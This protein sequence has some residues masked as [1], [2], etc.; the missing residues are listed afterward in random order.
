MKKILLGTTALVAATA[1]TAGVAKAD[2]SVSGWAY[3]SLGVTINTDKAENTAGGTTSYQNAG[4]D[5]K[6]STEMDS[7][8]TASL[9]FDFKAYGDTGGSVDEMKMS[10][11][12]DWGTLQLGTDDTISDVM[13][14][15]ANGV[16][17]NGVNDGGWDAYVGDGAALDGT[18]FMNTGKSLIGSDLA[19]VSYFSPSMNGLTFGLSYNADSSDNWTSSA[20]DSGFNNVWSAAAE[21]D[22][23]MSG[24]AVNLG[25]GAEHVADSNLV[26]GD[27]ADEDITLWK[28]NGS[29]G[30][31]GFSA[32]ATYQALD[33]NTSTTAKVDNWTL[34][35]SLGYSVAQH[36]MAVTW[37]TGEEDTG[38]AATSVDGDAYQISYSMDLGS[39][40]YW[41]ANLT[42]FDNQDGTTGNSSTR[43]ADFTAFETGIGVS[44]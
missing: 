14:G 4:M 23:E 2:M 9:H 20:G 15:S 25:L 10:L 43:D 35:T 5:F 22:G 16:S 11:S 19:I 37:L 21:Y 13:I 42:K 36:S 39:G 6:A 18:A 8:M 33:Y 7:G 27:G 44:F 28:V 12:D 32:G 31:G 17:F 34:A 1:M 41:D 40:V 3:Q 24:A 38:T 26:K 30:V 29:V